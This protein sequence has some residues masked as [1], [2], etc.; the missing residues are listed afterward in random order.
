MIAV[1]GGITFFLFSSYEDG[2]L[3]RYIST[4]AEERRNFEYT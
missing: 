2:P 3:T 4:G 1:G